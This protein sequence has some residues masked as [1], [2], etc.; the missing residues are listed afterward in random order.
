MKKIRIA[1]GS[2]LLC[3]ISLLAVRTAE[4][5]ELWPDGT[6]VI[7][8]IDTSGSM[9]ANDPDR[10]AVDSIEQFVYSLPT[11]HQVGLVSYSAQT[12]V[13]QSPVSSD[14]RKKV[15][16]RAEG[17]R[18]EGYSNAGAG[19]SDAV[20]LLSQTSAQEKYII[21]LSDGEI[22]LSDEE[23]T[24]EASGQYQEAVRQAREQ[25][26]TIHVIGLGSEMADPDSLIFSAAEQTGGSIF[27]EEKVQGIQDAVDEIRR[28]SFGI[29]Q[30]TLAIVDADG[31]METVSAALPYAHADKLRILITCDRPIRNLKVNLQAESA[32]QV[33][34]SRFAVIEIDRPTDDRLEVSFEGASGSRVWVNVIPEYYVLPRVQIGYTDTAP[35]DADI[36]V[37][38]PYDRTALLV[39]S[40]VSAANPTVQLWDHAYFDHSRI[41]VVM[42]EDGRETPLELFLEDG[43]LS[44][45]EQVEGSRTFTVRFDYSQLAV[46]VI[47]EDTLTAELE[48]APVIP[49]VE[50]ER[51]PPYLLIAVIAGCALLILLVLTIVFLILWRRSRKR[52]VLLPHDAKP[53]PSR[54]SYV[55]KLNIYVTRTRSGYDIPPLSYDLFRLP[56]GKVLSLYEV[57]DSCG[58]RERFPGAETI[59]LKAG[60]GRTLILTNNS[61]CTLMKNRE[62]LLKARSYQLPIDSKVDVTFED[63]VSELAFHYKDVRSSGMH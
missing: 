5:E 53:E 47:G 36:Y 18:Y 62:I 19:L 9:Q 52:P 59:Y 24:Q 26:I 58:V 4:A 39:Y 38:H 17:L 56:A 32:S 27:F 20:A 48:A 30:S 13:V 35:E 12:D 14:S 21:L 49:A 28:N 60:G 22:L 43:C 10:I 1:F 63:E 25:G 41:P 46:N 8:V 37:D 54:Y 15:A 2:F 55:G 50:P 51:E 31:T 45:Q 34:G 29:K 3:M 57:L 23:Q 6:A 7:F 40:F 33:N 44:M 11:D 61:D 42:T 16:V